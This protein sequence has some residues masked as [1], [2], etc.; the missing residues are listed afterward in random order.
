MRLY[1]WLAVAGLS[2]VASA[3]FA[4]QAAQTPAGTPALDPAQAR[5][6]L[7]LQRWEGQMGN[8]QTISA[9]CTRTTVDK[10]FQTT[11]VFEGSAKYMKPNLAMLDLQLRGKA[12][13]FEKYVCTGTFLYQYYLPNK[14]IRV[15]EMPAPKPGQVAEDNLMSFLFGMKAEEARRRYSLQLANEDRWYVYINIVPRFPADKADFSRARLV[16]N[17]QTFLPRELW[18]MQPNGNEVKWDIPRIENGAVLN[19]ADF[20][21]PAVPQGWTMK[22]MPKQADGGARNNIPPRIVRPNQ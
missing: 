22:R 20:T 17:N 19:R 10:T 4:Q 18:F 5:L 7:L 16:L 3:A 2:I 14:E 13:V 15:Y 9:Q 1:S 21:S 12:Q 8:V 11:E 6:N